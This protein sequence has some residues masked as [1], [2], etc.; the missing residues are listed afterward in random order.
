MKLQLSTC[1]PLIFFLLNSLGLGSTPLSYACS[2]KPQGMI[3][4]KY[5]A[6]CSKDYYKEI[7]ISPPANA[8]VSGQVENQIS[9]TNVGNVNNQIN[10]VPPQAGTSLGD[11]ITY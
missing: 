9:I 3:P 6:S 7:P 11:L 5:Y 10:T 4:G 2:V 8:D 1:L